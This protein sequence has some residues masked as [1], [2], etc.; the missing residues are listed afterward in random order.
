MEQPI[1]AGGGYQ[2]SLHAALQVKQ[3]PSSICETIFLTSIKDSLDVLVAHGLPA[4]YLALSHLERIRLRVRRML[5]Y[6][7]VNFW[8][9]MVGPNPLDRL[10]DRLEIDL[11]YFTSPSPLA[12]MTER[13]SYLYTVW[14]LAHRDHVEFPEASDRR[15][16]E[17]REALYRRALPKA[18]ATFVDSE[19][20]KQNMVRRYGLDPERVL[21]SPFSP[22]VGT[23]A[24]DATDPSRSV[25]IRSKYDI[26]GDY[27]LYP[28][29]FWPHKNHVY[30]LHGL[31]DLE[32][33]HG[34]KL[35]AVFPGS[36]KGNLAYVRETAREL[37]LSD[38]VFF[39]GFV[40]DNE[41]PSFYMQSLALVMPTYFGPT[42]MPPLE[43]FL[44]GVP[45]LY[46]DLPGLREQVGDAALLLDLNDPGCLA[47]HLFSLISTSGLRE[48]LIDRGRAALRAATSTHQE[49]L[50]GI[51]KA[52]G[53][54]K[55]AWSV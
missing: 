35:S 20:G 32:L 42:N 11:L 21:V 26:R 1:T 16:F 8:F 54:K 51:I 5:S 34:L 37:G 10:L 40:P 6:Q 4:R 41:I 36:D 18:V 24:Y 39:P 55:S 2:Q 53:V 25:D 45:V 7:A 23:V 31:A 49:L 27:V 47:E 22:A 43:A 28:A 9:R 52:F 38:R 29:Q 17:S 19:L 33:R 46:S 15:L 12:T 13:Y 48:Q 30:V 44:L 50:E 14:D 3:I